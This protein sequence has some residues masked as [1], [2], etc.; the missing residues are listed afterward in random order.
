MADQKTVHLQQIQILQPC[1]G[2][3][4]RSVFSLFLEW[5]FFL[6]S[7]STNSTIMAITIMPILIPE[8]TKKMRP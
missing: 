2:E 1:L 8:E 7:C 5:S 6:V 3:K 4:P